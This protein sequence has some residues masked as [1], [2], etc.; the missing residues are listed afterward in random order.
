MAHW[1]MPTYFAPGIIGGATTTRS[2]VAQEITTTAAATSATRPRIVLPEICIGEVHLVRVAAGIG[3]QNRVAPLQQPDGERGVMH[4]VA[5]FTLDEEFVPRGVALHRPHYGI[6]G[7]LRAA[8]EGLHPGFEH[9]VLQVS[10]HAIDFCL[11][12]VDHAV[13]V[14]VAAIRPTGD[15]DG[16]VIEIGNGVDAGMALV[17]GGN[18]VFA[19]DPVG[20][21]EGVIADGVAALE[22][23]AVHT[24]SHARVRG[25]FQLDG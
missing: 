18:V 23:V 24:F 25:V 5:E 14:I 13:A 6:G 12:S 2:T 1:S 16:L 4:A 15:H 9:L 17:A 19:A 7:I 8:S 22:H 11:H 3:A 20:D 21:A 10:E